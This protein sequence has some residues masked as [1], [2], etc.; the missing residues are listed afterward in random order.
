MT[1]ETKTNAELLAEYAAGGAGA[2]DAF[3][4]LAAEHGGMVHQVCLRILRREDLAEDAA[5]AVLLVL[6]RR[7]RSVKGEVGAFLHGVA[8]NVSLR[9]REAQMVRQKNE[10]D[11]AAMMNKRQM[12]LEAGDWKAVRERLDEAVAA[13][14]AG[15]RAA[16]TLHYLEGRPY[17]EVALRLSI[18]EGTVASRLNRALGRMRN[19]FKKQG[20]EISAAFLGPW[21]TAEAGG[22]ACPAYLAAT[23]SKLAANGGVGA[24]LS[25]NA[26]T[27]AKGV[28]RMMIWAK[29][30]TT[31][32]A[33]TTIILL[34]FGGPF[35]FHALSQEEKNENPPAGETVKTAPTK[36]G[37][38]RKEKDFAGREWTLTDWQEGER[39]YKK[40]LAEREAEYRK[41]WGEDWAGVKAN[42]GRS[43]GLYSP[44]KWAWED[45]AVLQGARKGSPGNKAG[46]P[47]WQKAQV[48]VFAPGDEVTAIYVDTAHGIYHIDPFTKEM[49]HAGVEWKDL[50]YH[51][52]KN[53]WIVWDEP[54]PELFKDGLDGNARLFPSR[55]QF[56]QY[57]TVDPV[58]GRLYFSQGTRIR[59]MHATGYVRSVADIRLRYV[60]K[61]LP[62]KVG[63]K[64]ML[65]PAILD[66]NE[67]YK[68]VGAEPV[69]VGGKRAKPRLAVRTT[70]LKDFKMAGF[71]RGWGEKIAITP[72]GKAVLAGGI[73]GRGKVEIVEIDT[74]KV[75]GEIK[76]DGA[77]PPSY[78]ADAHEAACGPEIDGLLYCCRHPGCGRGPGR[79][80][81]LDPKT[82]KITRLYDSLMAWPSL[83]AGGKQEERAAYT[84]ASGIQDGPADAV[85]LDFV[86][87]CF[88]NQCPRTG[89][90]VNGGWDGSGLRR[91]HDGFV[92]T[93]IDS[94]HG[95]KADVRFG[96]PEWNEYVSQFAGLQQPPA[97]GPDGSIYI[98][99]VS[100]DR[101]PEMKRINTAW[102][103]DVLVIRISRTDWP[104]EQ[105][106]NG[107]AN[108]FLSP[109]KREEL[110]LEYVKKYIANY[111]ELSKIY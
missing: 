88:Q 45:F 106:V 34:G 53:A 94:Q 84:K 5:Q 32:M 25:G 93:W 48:V 87:T 91:Y 75:L 62:Y 36:P 14:P 37:E 12:A 78:A 47:R 2:T 55:N 33:C 86:T 10:E 51:T 64:E 1:Q 65:L 15:E 77:L 16:V 72:D 27:L 42:A 18:P 21:L 59:D 76:V 9:A 103:G 74:G 50:K 29:V 38:F 54:M 4:R 26:T 105:P 17:A 28:M 63:G 3:E 102:D 20:V 101:S 67:M 111:E 23:A 60:E 13:L 73:V 68:K 96:R 89:A 100:G 97:I 24:V 109:E 85:T 108:Q 35:L 43:S 81:S 52:G 61:L 79:L 41:K 40:N 95:G 7:A 66:H 110:R 69:I 19:F 90:V 46:K 80:F 11:A 70:P 83:E 6:A 107:Y 49:V 30:K 31:A 71:G 8:V 56:G 58:T 39:P 98:V 92:T 99:D 57:M 22:G 82:G 44:G 104:K